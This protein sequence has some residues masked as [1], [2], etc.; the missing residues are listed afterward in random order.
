MFRYSQRELLVTL[1]GGN[2]LRSWR[3]PGRWMSDSELDCLRNTIKK[4]TLSRV[5]ALPEYGIYLPGRSPY[6]DRIIT[7]VYAGDES[8]PIAFSAMIHCPIRIEKRVHHVLHLGLVIISRSSPG[9]NL[10]FLIYF[11]PIAH[12]WATRSFSG[13]W[14]SSVSK[15]PSI[16]GAVADYFGNVYPHYLRKTRPTRT[17]KE[18]A[19]RFVSEYG[20]EFG[21]GP[22]GVLNEKTFIIQASCR[23][24]SEVLRSSFEKSAKYA[25]HRCNE[26]CRESLNYERGDELLQI[27]NLNAR[28]AL[29]AGLRWLRA[30]WRYR[31]HM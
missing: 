3:F 20:H 21:I 25:I 26:F 5:G 7:V 18:I 9:R 24:T 13:F 29:H 14:V 8:R 11:F 23:G 17:K 10:L 30:L 31:G 16:I 12:Y 4:I 15:E 27:G 2:N 22:G 19:R 28:T 1:R 6:K